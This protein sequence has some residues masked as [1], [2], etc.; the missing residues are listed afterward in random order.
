[1]LKIMFML[2]EVQGK[3]FTKINST[4]R[5]ELAVAKVVGKNRWHPPSVPGQVKN[6]AGS[7]SQDCERL[8]LEFY[9]Q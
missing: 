6:V 8:P 4:R 2:R 3:L 1:M 9:H 7:A 5:R